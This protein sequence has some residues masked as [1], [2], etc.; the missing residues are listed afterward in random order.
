MIPYHI[1]QQQKAQQLE[2]TQDREI[3]GITDG[4]HAYPLQV[5]YI[6]DL[7]YIKGYVMGISQWATE[8]QD[9]KSVV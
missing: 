3:E 4:S 1:D 6:H 8:L 5:K 2:G 7:T 9:R